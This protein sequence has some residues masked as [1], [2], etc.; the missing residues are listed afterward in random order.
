MCLNMKFSVLIVGRRRNEQIPSP[1][2]VALVLR[3]VMG[4]ATTNEV[5]AD[6]SIA[7][8]SLEKNMD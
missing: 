1:V 5:T 7:A 4:T 2:Y 6:N 3:S 8:V